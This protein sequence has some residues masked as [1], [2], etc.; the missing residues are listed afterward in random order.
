MPSHS[1]A[2]AGLVTVT[3]RERGVCLQRLAACR[4]RRDCKGWLM[5][6]RDME[7]GSTWRRTLHVARVGA[8]ACSS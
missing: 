2:D 8:L 5:V 4:T 6:V 1:G 7:E 3:Q